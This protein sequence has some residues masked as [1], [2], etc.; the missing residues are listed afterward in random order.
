MSL[1]NIDDLCVRITLPRVLKQPKHIQQIIKCLEYSVK[2]RITSL[3][4]PI[5]IGKLKK[6]KKCMNTDMQWDIPTKTI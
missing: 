5:A 3:Q 2:K 4:N 1:I 6:K